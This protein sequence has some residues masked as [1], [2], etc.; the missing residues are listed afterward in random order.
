M[1]VF[2]SSLSSLESYT[3][4]L[5]TLPK[6]DACQQCLQ[7]NQWVSHGY[8]YKQSSSHQKDVTGKRILCSSRYG[9]TGCGHTRR[10]YLDDYIPGRRYLLEAVVTFIH[11]LIQGAA[12]EDA[13]R[14]ATGTPGQE[15]RHAWRWLDALEARLGQFRTTLRQ[16]SIKAETSMTTYRTRRLN[17]LLP[18][19]SE[20]LRLQN[21]SSSI[22]S[23]L[24]YRFI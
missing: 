7:N 16:S 11:L 19:L 15:A 8:V 1:Q 10:L 6:D 20:I 14:R 4:S 21:E 2:F 23:F 3:R 17:I 12:I 9:R 24:K 13:Y 18:T 22:Q 5:Q